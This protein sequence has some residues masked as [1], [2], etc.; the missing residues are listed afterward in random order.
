MGDSLW[1]QERKLTNRVVRVLSS[2]ECGSIRFRLDNISIQTFMY[3][4]VASAIGDSLSVRIV[5]SNSYDDAT[6]TINLESAD[7][8]SDAIVHEA[9]HAVIDCTNSGV[10]VSVGTHEASAYLAEAIYALN[11]DR[12][13]QF[14]YRPM[15][16][17]IHRLAEAVRAF[18]RN[19]RSG[20]FRCPTPQVEEIKQILAHSPLRQNFDRVYQQNGFH[21]GRSGRYYY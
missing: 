11:C 17:P 9:T 21:R 1:T 12:F 3:R 13:A 5:G 15:S 19:N 8:S 20:L 4:H 6:D 16:A 14:D 2:E 18:N 10:G 7:V